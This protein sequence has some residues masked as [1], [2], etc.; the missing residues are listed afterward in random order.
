MIVLYMTQAPAK[1]IVIPL[2]DRREETSPAKLESLMQ[3]DVVADLASSGIVTTYPSCLQTGIGP[4]GRVR[5][6]LGRQKMMPSFFP[7]KSTY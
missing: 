2:T 1:L 5:L 7:P 4:D 6:I 3:Y